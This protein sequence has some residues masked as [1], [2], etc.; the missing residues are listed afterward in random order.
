MRNLLAFIFATFAF[1]FFVGT[2]FSIS[3]ETYDFYIARE[4]DS[5][6]LI[7]TP[8]RPYTP[9][10]VAQPLNGWHGVFDVPA[11]FTSEQLAEMIIHAPHYTHTRPSIPHPHRQMTDLERTL[12]IAD[13][14]TMGGINAQEFELYKIVNEIRAEYGLPPFIL[15]PRLS[16]ASRLFSYLQ[17]RE[18]ST[19]HTDPYYD[20]MITRA[21]FFGAVG[22]LYMENANSQRWYVLPSGII[23]YIHLTPY[24]LVEVWMSSDDHRDHIL[25]TETT[26]AGFGVDSGNNRVVPTMKTM[27]PRE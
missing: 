24:G 11:I 14:N 21:L 15:C 12:W 8:Q 26:H 13:Y 27:M 5:R 9:E 22:S 23:E 20:D 19:G 2:I 10:P 6:I 18:H 4:D 17:V 7:R 1:V 25:T 16:K 3:T